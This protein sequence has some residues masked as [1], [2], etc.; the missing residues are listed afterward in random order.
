MTEPGA[1]S[2]LAGIRTSAVREGDHYVLNGQKTFISNGPLNDLGIVVARTNP[3]H[4]HRGI[5]LLVVERE[6]E[7]YRRGLNLEKIGLH[8]QDTAELFSDN[9]RVPAE[10]M[11]GREGEGFSYLM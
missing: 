11:L 5:S 3:G 10:N 7:C 6:M 1:G 4:A 8:A 9:V 2:D